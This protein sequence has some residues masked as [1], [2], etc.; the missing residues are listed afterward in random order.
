MKFISSLLVSTALFVVT[1]P[2]GS[3]NC[4][5]QGL[6]LSQKS[7]AAL[8]FP[9][10]P[11]R[12]STGH[13]RLVEDPEPLSSEEIKAAIVNDYEKYNVNMRY[14]LY[15]LTNG[16]IETS[17]Y[18]FNPVYETSHPFSKFVTLELQGPG[19]FL[20]GLLSFQQKDHPD[21]KDHPAFVL[22][23]RKDLQRPEAGR[24]I[25]AS[26][27]L[28]HILTDGT[29]LSVGYDG[30][31]DGSVGSVGTSQRYGIRD[32]VNVFHS[33]G[34]KKEFRNIVE[35]LNN[36]TKAILQESSGRASVARLDEPLE[37]RRLFGAL[38]DMRVDRFLYAQQER[39]TREKKK[40]E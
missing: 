10:K 16:G 1:T 40:I 28:K 24:F 34:S 15:M 9:M 22:A 26:K 32:I 33:A 38:S 7:I 20:P 25:W 30:Q 29:D 18:P 37:H 8:L 5:V 14:V 21:K 36:D 4:E 13:I 23:S 3:S 27:K 19:L 31:R 6:V 17:A 12:L 11:S 39:A 2:T 35:T